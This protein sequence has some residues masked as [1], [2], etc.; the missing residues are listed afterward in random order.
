MTGHLILRDPPPSPH[1]KILQN[2]DHMPVSF[3]KFLILG[4]CDRLRIVAIMNSLAKLARITQKTLFNGLYCN[5]NIIAQ[6]DVTFQP[7]LLFHTTTINNRWHKDRVEN[8]DLYRHGYIDRV[9][10]SGAMPRISED[11]PRIKEIKVF[12]PS[13]P[14]APKEALFGQNDYIDI[15]GKKIICLL[16]KVIITVPKR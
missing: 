5:T 1:A 4:K 8:R 12:R 15:L 6:A 11:S 2:C 13:N 7:S 9:K 16:K 10:Q 14:F 3:Q